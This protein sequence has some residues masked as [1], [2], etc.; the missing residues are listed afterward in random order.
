MKNLLIIIATIF[1]T[2]IF[3]QN[4]QVN[5]LKIGAEYKTKNEI[6]DIMGAIPTNIREPQPTDEEPNTYIFHF[7]EDSVLWSD[8]HI[9][10]IKLNTNRFSFNN[11]I[12][13]GDNISAIKG[14]GGISEDNGRGEIFW[15]P[16]ADPSINEGWDIWFLYH[17]G[18][19]TQIIIG[20]IQMTGI[21]DKQQHNI[22]FAIAD[23]VFLLLARAQSASSLCP[24]FEHRFR[25][26]KE[27]LNM[28]T[29]QRQMPA[30]LRSS[31]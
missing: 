21:F 12:R 7:G 11:L 28:T 2:N 17:D 20:I 5:G 3:A 16:S 15:K 9:L 1:C 4:I 22:I 30:S 8:N 18:K 24:C 13:V 19:I 14:L 31:A 10:E 6:F 26:T 25:M 27:R 29:A 23:F